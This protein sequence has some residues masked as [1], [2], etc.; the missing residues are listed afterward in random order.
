MKA[1]TTMMHVR[2]LAIVAV[3]IVCSTHA[4]GGQGLSQY[5]NFELGSNVAKV[6]HQRP[7]VLQ[8]LEWRLSRW[9][10]GS[11]EVSTD[12]VERLQFSFYD[13]QLF[14]ILVDYDRDRTKGMTGVDLI[15]A[16]SKIYGPPL[17]RTVGVAGRTG[18]RLETESG[19]PLARWGDSKHTVVLYDTSSYADAFRLVVTDVR[20][21]NLARKAEAQAV[22]LDDQEAP[23]REIARQRQER[24]DARAA[25]EKARAVNKVVFR[26]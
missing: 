9:I 7:A 21:E 20:L 2:S 24:D 4:L 18:S 1:G 15:E 3:G 26:P 6:I 5:R 13:D 14:R 17:P 25:A 19:A 11:S 16:I 22:R 12:P 23:A 8:D 10:P